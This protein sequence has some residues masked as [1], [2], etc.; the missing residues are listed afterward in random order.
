[1]TTESPESVRIAGISRFS[2]A[3]DSAEVIY[4]AY[5]APNPV[6]RTNQQEFRPI[7]QP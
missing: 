3:L 7:S 4:V 5:G 6:P 2:D 1:M